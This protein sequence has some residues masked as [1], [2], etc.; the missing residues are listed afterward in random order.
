[1]KTLLG[2]FVVVL[3]VLGTPVRAEAE[4]I[5]A[6]TFFNE[7]IT[8][9]SGTPA[10]LTS[11][12]PITGLVLTG[13]ES[14]VGIDFRPGTG[15]LYGVSNA[16]RL[17]RID[18]ASGAATLVGPIA[19]P[20]VSVGTSVGVDFN[21]VADRLRLVGNNDTNLRINPI[22]A[23]FVFDLPLAY[24]AGDPNFGRNPNVVAAAYT[25]SFPGAGF[26]TL[27]GIDSELRVLVIQDPPNDGTLHTIGSLG[28]PFPITQVAGFDISGETGAAYA[29]LALG[30]VTNFS[31][32]FTIDLN[33]GQA[34]NLGIIGGVTSFR[35]VQDIAVAPVPEPASLT[36]CGVGLAGL[37]AYG[38]R[39]RRQPARSSGRPRPDHER[40]PLKERE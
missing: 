25:N 11:N 39:K 26:T 22:D 9:D 14:L 16:N 2:C 13:V 15:E 6:I 32:F 24:A 21:P 35:L 31:T 36:L 30:N 5:Y 40:G 18:A 12:V 27:Y 17:Y 3:C 37:S 23:S 28:I 1:M 4:T 34:T 29:A 10:V 33:T 19:P 20:G 7:L 8:F 38:W